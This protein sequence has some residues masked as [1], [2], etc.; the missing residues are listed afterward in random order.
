[1]LLQS[2][3]GD[4]RPICYCFWVVLDQ[5]LLLS[6]TKSWESLQMWNMLFLDSE[7]CGLRKWQEDG[8]QNVHQ[9][10]ACRRSV[11]NS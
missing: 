9:H 6:L 3:F 5:I 4:D 11:C 1:M 8:V 7:A 10:A 2:K